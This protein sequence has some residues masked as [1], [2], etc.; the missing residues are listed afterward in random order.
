VLHPTVFGEN[1]TIA[2][3]KIRDAIIRGVDNLGVMSPLVDPLNWNQTGTLST[4]GQAFG[5]MLFAAW[6]DWIATL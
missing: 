4:E 6:K 5:L 2:A 1:Y 3:S